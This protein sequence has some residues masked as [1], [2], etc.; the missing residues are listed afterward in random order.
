MSTV[1]MSVRQFSKRSPSQAWRRSANSNRSEIFQNHMLHFQSGNPES[2]VIGGKNKFA[3]VPQAFDR[4][5][6]KQILYVGWGPQ[7]SAQAPN[8]KKTLELAGRS[9]IKVCVGLRPDS[10]SIP[11]AK[12]EGFNEEDGT[13]GDIYALAAQSDLIFC[14]IADG[15]MVEIH[16]ALFSAAKP[17]AIIGL[18]HGF[19]AGHLQSIGTHFPPDR[20]FIMVAPKG[21]G[22]SV[23]ALY[24]QG[25]ETEGAGINSSVAIH[26]HSRDAKRSR[27]YL[28]DL[29]N[30]VSV[31]IG[32]PVTFGTDFTSEVISDLFGE[33]AMLLGGLYGAVEALFNYYRVT[34]SFH[35]AFRFSTSGLTGTVREGLSRLGIEGFY[36]SLSGEERVSFG[37]G[38]LVGYPTC[39]L[40]HD[41]IYQSVSSFEEI[42]EVVI[43]T[44]NLQR[45]PMK[46][47]GTSDM[48]RFA[49]EKKWYGE[50]IPMCKELAFSAGVYVGGVMSHLHTLLHHGHCVSET[51][52]EGLIEALDSLIPY[53]HARGV[54][55][56][57]DN[58]SITARLGTRKWAGV[59]KDELARVLGGRRHHGAL[60]T[61]NDD[62][63]H[64]DIG[65][66]YSLRPK[67]A[68]NVSL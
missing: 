50:S 29:A 20:D 33:R 62:A 30:A 66:L 51:I 7:A 35:D 15:A 40:I 38:Y 17:G 28:C 43:A 53:M 61:L 27:Y 41:R 63:L 6:I 5:G 13:L 22:A 4:S 9:D 57:V 3:L 54:G 11:L 32:S 56:M 46:P 14:L 68:I 26:L 52:N 34:H 2:V 44:S 58:C 31:G 21:M 49:T 37:E 19:L 47:I 12:V 8:L 59:Y 1:S 65:I 24:L 16:K 64:R 55:Y 67:V 10:K 42:K 48:W 18:A 45:E 39:D 25:L 36:Q 60:V 23:R